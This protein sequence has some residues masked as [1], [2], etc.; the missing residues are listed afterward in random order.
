MIEILLLRRSDLGNEGE[1]GNIKQ[2]INVP[3]E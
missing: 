2:E 3:K 1:P